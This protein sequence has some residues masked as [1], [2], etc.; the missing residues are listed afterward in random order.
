MALTP[1]YGGTLT[2][3]GTTHTG[4][5]INFDHNRLS[6]DV[7]QMSDIR[8]KKAPGRYSRSGSFEMIAQTSTTDNAIRSH[9]VP[10]DLSA[11]TGASLAL[12]YTGGGGNS[13]SIT[14]HL[15]RASR[16]DGG[17]GSSPGIW[18]CDFEEQ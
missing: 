7:T 2:L 3:G 14:V 4:R 17:D 9:M 15:T 13:Y 10:A 1:G 8:V 12:V 11:A 16:V 18:Q 5:N 6:V